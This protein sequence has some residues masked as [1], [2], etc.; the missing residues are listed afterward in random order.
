M[1]L[2]DHDLFQIDEESIRKLG[3]KDSEALTKL[4]I[5]LLEDLVEARNRLNQNPS[6]SSRPSGSMPPWESGKTD[7]DTETKPPSDGDLK[8]VDDDNRTDSDAPPKLPPTPKTDESDNAS[9]SESSKM[10]GRQPGSQGFGRTQKLSITKTIGHFVRECVICGCNNFTENRQ[11]AWT[12]YEVVDLEYGDSGSP[13]VELTNTK[14]IF[15]EATCGCGHHNRETP[16]RIAQAGDWSGVTLTEWR[17]VGPALASLIIYLSME[18]RM[19]RRRVQ[20]FFLD[21][22]ALKIAV[23][24]IQ[25]T[26][27]ESAAAVA[28]LEKEMVDNLL[29]E[30]LMHA[31]ETPHPE[32]GKNLWLWC[33]ITSATALFYVGHRTSEIFQILTEDGYDG[34]LMSDGYKV[35]RHF[36]KRLRCWAHLIRKARGLRDSLT[37]TER[38][39]GVQ[40]LAIMEDELMQ[41]VYRVREGGLASAHRSIIEEH[42]ESLDILKALCEKMA[43]SKLKKTSELGKEFLNDW[44]AIFRVLELPMLPLTNN[45]AEQRL[46]HWVLL[47]RISQGTRSAQGSRALGLLASVITTCR[48]RLA[49]PLHYIQ[50]VIR[51]RREGG[52]APPLPPIPDSIRE[53]LAPLS[54]KNHLPASLVEHAVQCV[55]FDEGTDLAQAA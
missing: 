23:G 53:R 18:M 11:I 12:A 14:H 37:P 25:N 6:N 44:D 39:Y 24:T 43:K 55:D 22:F 52:A 51:L 7:T 38:R 50:D 8:D 30:T 4:T 34:W 20:L 10:P 36:K 29:K 26:I 31:D 3:A 5:N 42:R 16:S 35:Y 54:L 13:G 17:L 2:K 21:L 15:Y 45:E 46:R 49:S 27:I 28:P 32:H 33:F 9:S 19:S 48:L 41:A 1:H 40:I 47:R